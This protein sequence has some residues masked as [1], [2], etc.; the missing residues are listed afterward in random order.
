MSENSVVKKKNRLV[1][2]VREPTNRWA[3]FLKELETNPKAEFTNHCCENWDDV[4]YTKAEKKRR[5]RE[6]FN[7]MAR[8]SKS[9]KVEGKLSIQ[10]KEDGV[11]HITHTEKRYEDGKLVSD[12]VVAD[13]DMRDGIELERMMS[14]GPL[15]MVNQVSTFLQNLEYLK[16]TIGKKIK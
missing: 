4:S 10:T 8:S 1:G 12:R 7:P 14:T 9:T 3:Q 2:M 11:I 16:N 5:H 13:K 15:R 6:A